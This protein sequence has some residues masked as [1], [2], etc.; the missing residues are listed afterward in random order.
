M[1]WGGSQLAGG[2]SIS[3]EDK[4]GRL[5]KG[6]KGKGENSPSSSWRCLADGAAMG[7]DQ[8]FRG[9]LLFGDGIFL[10]RFAASGGRAEKLEVP[11]PASCPSAPLLGQ[12]LGPPLAS[13]LQAWCLAGAQ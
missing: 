7:G 2:G 6:E 10:W 3:L 4:W 1:V 12:A 9:S 11:P 5:G 8:E 13:H